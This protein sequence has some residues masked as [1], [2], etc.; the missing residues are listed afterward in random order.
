MQIKNQK[1]QTLLEA[2]VALGL[3]VVIASGVAV[4]SIYSLN[5]SSFS[6]LQTN[7]AQY[8][9]EGIEIARKM[10]DTNYPAYQ[11]L[12]STT[13]YCV[14]KGNTTI[15]NGTTQP[16]CADVGSPPYNIDQTYIRQIDVNKTA[17]ACPGDL[18]KVT[19]AV[20][21]TDGKC[22]LLPASASDP[23]A[24]HYCH[25]STVVACLGSPSTISI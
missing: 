4:L 7:A 12:L 17:G 21:W 14:A 8:A 10:R 16:S 25:S 13:H 20:S 5:N 22:P 6:K 18:D 1:G 19:V 23:K 2:V 3:A 9:Q 15:N 24:P 11:A